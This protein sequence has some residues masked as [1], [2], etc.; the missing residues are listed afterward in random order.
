MTVVRI[1]RT[2]MIERPGVEIPLV[3]SVELDSNATLLERATALDAL[4]RLA[5]TAEDLCPFCFAPTGV[6][7]NIE[8]YYAPDDM[9]EQLHAEMEEDLANG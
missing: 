1:E 8:C 5:A 6:Y 7:H 4:D 2:V 3:F 9:L